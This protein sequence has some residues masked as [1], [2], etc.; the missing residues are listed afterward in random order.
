M[1]P[2]SYGACDA[3]WELHGRGDR[4]NSLQFVMESM[5]SNAV[6]FL[7]HLFPEAPCL[8]VVLLL[9]SSIRRFHGKVEFRFLILRYRHPANGNA[10]VANERHADAMERSIDLT[11]SST[12]FFVL[13]N[14]VFDTACLTR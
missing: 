10:H 5:C 1:R 13:Y 12:L 14:A 2:P 11:P 4:H 6:F 7:E 8:L 3:V 9:C